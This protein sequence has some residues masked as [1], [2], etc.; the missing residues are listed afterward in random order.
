MWDELT[1]VHLQMLGD[2]RGAIFLS[3]LKM[4][5]MEL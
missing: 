4:S 5:A 1:T 2:L 3:I